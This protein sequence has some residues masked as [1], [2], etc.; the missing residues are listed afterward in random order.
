MLNFVGGKLLTVFFHALI[1]SPSGTLEQAYPKSGSFIFYSV[2]SKGISLF[3][4]IRHCLEAPTVWLLLTKDDIQH[5]HIPRNMSKDNHFSLT[6]NSFMS[7]EFKVD[8]NTNLTVVKMTAELDGAMIFCGTSETLL[9][10]FTLIASSKSDSCII[11]F[12]FLQNVNI[13]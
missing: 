5:R 8:L 12:Y 7:D 3:C 4:K 1:E 11:Y 6:G 10:N 2:G 9:G 13:S